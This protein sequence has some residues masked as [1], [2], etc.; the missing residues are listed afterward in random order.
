MKSYALMEQYARWE[1]GGAPSGTP[2]RSGLETR[3][4]LLVRLVSRIGCVWESSLW[5]VGVSPNRGL[6]KKE[7]S[8]RSHLC[9]QSLGPSPGKHSG[10]ASAMVVYVELSL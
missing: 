8:Y 10:V 2:T 5:V 1:S 3:C 6:G 9:S 4:G 7:V